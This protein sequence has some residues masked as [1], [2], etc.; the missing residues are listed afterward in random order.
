MR[1]HVR[2]TAVLLVMALLSGCMPGRIE[3]AAPVS[4]PSIEP[5]AESYE[6]PTVYPTEEPSGESYADL[7]V[8][9]TAE[10]TAPPT[11]APTEAPTEAPTKEAA[12][13][14]SSQ[15]GPTLPSI[16]TSVTEPPT[17]PPTAP[18]TEAPTEP[19]PSPKIGLT[20]L[21]VVPNYVNVRSGPTTSDAVVGKIF[22]NCAAE[23]LDE[24]DGE[25]GK[26]FLMTSGNVQGYIKSEFFL[27][28]EEA[29]AKK[30]EVGVIWGLVKED[31]LRV[32][33]TPDMSNNDNV[34]THYQKGTLVV[35]K[36]LSNGWAKIESDES[37]TGYVYADCIDYWWEFKKAITLQEEAAEL[38]RKKEAEERARKAQE[39]YE[40]ALRAEQ[41]RQRQ[42]EEEARRRSEEAARQTTPPPGQPTEPP[43]APPPTEPPT[44]PPATE[45]PVDP[46]DALRNA[47]VAYALQFV[48][49]PY[50]HGGRSLVT[51]TDCSGFTSLVYQH[52]GY[53]LSYTPAGQSQQYTRVPLDSLK[54]G[55]LLFYSNAQKYLGHVAMY[56]GNGQIV[57]AG[58]V[59]TGVL[60]SSAYYRDPLFAVRVIN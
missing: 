51:G 27:V 48:G 34:F 36:E 18:P 31:Y 5:S 59:E 52:F 42:A 13:D 53:P 37:S 58:T 8:Q 14:R 9:P 33:S 4:E 47:V 40:A 50:V 11:D 55:D 17:D 49:N 56:I 23:I 1:K 57:H 16:S 26:W 44:A 2:F 12:S 22:N 35:I 6:D 45:P 7:T 3:T 28:G 24:V 43:T 46:K 39:E 60:V 32:R 38:Q 10:P 21:A 30:K 15:E 25:D 41:E 20:A 19:T 54:P 29:E